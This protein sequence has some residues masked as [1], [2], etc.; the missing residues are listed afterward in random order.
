ME[1]AKGRYVQFGEPGVT[2][3]LFWHP[4]F[5]PDFFRGPLEDKRRANVSM[6]WIEFKSP[7]K[8]PQQHQLAWHEAERARGALVVVVD[9]YETFRDWYRGVFS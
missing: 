9:H 2:D 7:G 3:W 6:L 4:M 1:N 8:K 5:T